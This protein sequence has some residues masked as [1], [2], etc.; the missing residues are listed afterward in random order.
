MTRIAFVFFVISFQS[1]GRNIEVIR[2]YNIAKTG[3]LDIKDELAVATKV[4]EGRITS[5]PSRMPR[6]ARAK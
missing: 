4:N 1:P 5:S 3:L 6:L 2:A